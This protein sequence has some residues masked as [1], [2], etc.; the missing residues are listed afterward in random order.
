MIANFYLRQVGCFHIVDLFL[1]CLFVCLLI[2]LRRIN[3]P[4]SITFC[5]EVGHDPG[6]TRTIMEWIEKSR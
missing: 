3:Q 6:G 2:G 5:G 4:I 1:F